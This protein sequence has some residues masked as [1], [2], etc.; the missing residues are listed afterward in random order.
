LS[1]PPPPPPRVIS[2]LFALA[3]LLAVSAYAQP[4]DRAGDFRW[5]PAENGVTI[6]GRTGPGTDI[7]IPPYI[8]GMPVTE[9]GPGAFLNTGL[10]SVTIPHTVTSIG[11][12]AFAYN[13]LKSVSLPAGVTYIG[14]VA[15]A[16][17]RFTEISI[18]ASVAS[19]GYGSFRDN[20]LTSVVIPSG[21]TLVGDGAFGEALVFVDA[22][23]AEPQLFIP[24][25]TA[26]SA[27]SL[28]EDPSRLWSVGL[29]GAVS[30]AEPLLDSGAFVAG[31]TL[32]LT[33]APWRNSFIRIGCDIL[34]GSHQ[35]HGD[36]SML[37]VYPFAHLALFLP[38]FGWYGGVY[39]GAGAGFMVKSYSGHY[40]E[41]SDTFFAADIFTVGI[42]F[43]FPFMGRLGLNASYTMR[44]DFSAL[45]DRFALGIVYRFRTGG[46]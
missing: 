12:M 3:A 13:E 14:A 31:G 40:G 18:P 41:G 46:R 44:T 24:P 19:I 27:P 26:H 42:T 43:T 45:T 4:H 38:L 28:L 6:T 15:F 39:A 32:Q 1:C 30:L 17:N 21:V 34:R 16:R 2:C 7:R 5:E 20:E 33:L 8:H 9:I 35:D 23:G 36:F 37:T 10:T 11:A 25:L 29:S 22:G